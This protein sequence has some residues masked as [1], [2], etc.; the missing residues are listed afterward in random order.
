MSKFLSE[1]HH[2]KAAHYR[3]FALE[4]PR[5]YNTDQFS[6]MLNELERKA[7]L[8]FEHAIIGAL[9]RKEVRRPDDLSNRKAIVVEFPVAPEM[10]QTLTN[11][12]FAKAVL[13]GY[14]GIEFTQIV[15]VHTRP[16]WHKFEFI[17]YQ[18]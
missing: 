4:A 2:F 12:S 14:F 17:F 10:M 5:D 13:S 9:Q 11:E 1:L 3:R 6:L 7:K 8:Y 18:D 15:V 16:Y